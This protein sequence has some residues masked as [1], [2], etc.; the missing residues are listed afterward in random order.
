MKGLPPAYF[1]AGRLETPYGR[2]YSEAPGSG[3]GGDGGWEGAQQVGAAG[4][5]SVVNRSA[6]HR[7]TGGTFKLN[8]GSYTRTNEGGAPYLLYTSDIT[9]PTD[10]ALVESRLGAF[11]R[12]RLAE[13]SGG[14]LEHPIFFYVNTALMLLACFLYRVTWKYADCCLAAARCVRIFTDDI[15]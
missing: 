6:S 15:A 1:D 11:G 3:G 2:G 14:K 10:P 8:K 13:G 9:S 4:S 7:S 12:G 5:G